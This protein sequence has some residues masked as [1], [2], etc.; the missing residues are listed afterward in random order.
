[1]SICVLIYFIIYKALHVIARDIL[2]EKKTRLFGE[3]ENDQFGF[4]KVLH[5][6]EEGGGK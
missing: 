6:C 3:E 2:Y 5:Q 1:M 4:E